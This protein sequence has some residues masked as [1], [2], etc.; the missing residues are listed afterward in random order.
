[1]YYVSR[2][3]HHGG[4]IAFGVI[5][6][7]NGNKE[8]IMNWSS[9]AE[10]I[11]NGNTVVGVQAKVGKASVRHHAVGEMSILP[12][13]PPESKSAEQLKYAMIAGVDTTVN[14]TM[15]TSI[16]NL[17]TERHLPIRLSDVCDSCADYIL[18]AEAPLDDGKM[19]IVL[20]DAVKFTRKTF[21]LITSYDQDTDTGFVLDVSEMSDDKALFVYKHVAMELDHIETAFSTIVDTKNRQSYMRRGVYKAMGLY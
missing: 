18:F 10:F 2:Y 17:K 11:C 5:D 9:L 1:M 7:C 12:Y 19:V 4:H 21:G 15:L 14:G 13:Q 3:V 6:T 16:R 20:D 8:R